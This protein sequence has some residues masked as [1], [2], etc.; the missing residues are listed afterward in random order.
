M[1]GANDQGDKEISVNLDDGYLSLHHAE[2]SVGLN[3]QN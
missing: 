3:F 2:I 1:S